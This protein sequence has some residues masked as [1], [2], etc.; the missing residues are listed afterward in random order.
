MLFSREI[1]GDSNQLR[2]LKVELTRVHR[3]SFVIIGL[4][5][6]LFQPRHTKDLILAPIRISN[7][8]DSV[9]ASIQTLNESQ[10][11]TLDDR[12]PFFL[13]LF[14]FLCFSLNNKQPARTVVSC[15]FKYLKNN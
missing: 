5:S 7:R 4:V 11:Q 3:Q 6:D 9:R 2:V 12:V 10:K 14:L 15:S 8:S 1:S 13:F